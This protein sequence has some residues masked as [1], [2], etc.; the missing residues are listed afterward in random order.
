MEKVTGAQVGDIYDLLCERFRMTPPEALRLIA[1]H[2]EDG[3]V[4]AWT[5]REME[6]MA[7]GA[8]VKSSGTPGE[9]AAVK[10]RFKVARELKRLEGRLDA[11]DERTD[12][13]RR[14]VASADDRLTELEM[15]EGTP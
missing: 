8:A 10:T 13:L 6:R 11:L 12:I 4:G 3:D 7:D 2:A 9:W 5:L 1:G 14:G 15:E